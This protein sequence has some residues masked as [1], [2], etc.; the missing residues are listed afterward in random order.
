MCYTLGPSLLSEQNEC[1]ESHTVE[2]DIVYCIL[3]AESFLS[4]LSLF[5]FPQ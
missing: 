5:F 4:S 2:P 3:Y 1:S